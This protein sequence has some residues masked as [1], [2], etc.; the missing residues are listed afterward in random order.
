M[1]ISRDAVIEYTIKVSAKADPTTKETIDK[2]KEGKKTTQPNTKPVKEGEEQL[3]DKPSREEFENQGVVAG[4]DLKNFQTDPFFKTPEEE[5]ESGTLSKQA[6][7]TLN[8]IDSQGLSNLSSFASNPQQTVSNNLVK[9]LTGLGPEGAALVA[10]IGSAIAIPEVAQTLLNFL[11]E[12]GGPLNRDF[13]RNIGAE[14]DAGLSRQL[15]RQREVG[16]DQVIIGQNK[17]FT[18]NNAEWQY[19]SYYQ[20]TA[21]RISR[22]GLSDRSTGILQE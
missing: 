7:D 8:K 6:T 1:S 4:G 2:L 21:A 10:A 11:S 13:K 12:P 17:G 9:I 5:K 18:P 15:V 16:I 3:Q 14:V 20:I 22:I 19:N